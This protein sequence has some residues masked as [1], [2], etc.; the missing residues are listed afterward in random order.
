[1]PIVDVTHRPDLAG[2]HLELLAERLPV[3]AWSQAD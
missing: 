3:A 1:M 2:D